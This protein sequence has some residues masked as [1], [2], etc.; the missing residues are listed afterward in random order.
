M[1]DGQHPWTLSAPRLTVHQHSPEGG[2]Q[3]NEAY[4]VQNEVKRMGHGISD[5]SER[6]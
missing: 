3:K 4:D 6:V 5:I 1:Q 2:C